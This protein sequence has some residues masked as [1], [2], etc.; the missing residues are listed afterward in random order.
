M[1]DFYAKL[2]IFAGKCFILVVCKKNWLFDVKNWLV[3]CSIFSVYYQYLMDSEMFHIQKSDLESIGLI[4]R[5]FKS[6]YVQ[7]E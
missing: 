7:N 3:G 5:A 4:I 1:L 2:I 6:M